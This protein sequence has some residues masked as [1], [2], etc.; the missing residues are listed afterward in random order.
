MNYSVKILPRAEI[1]LAEMYAYIALRSP[2]GAEQWLE[3]FEAVIERLEANPFLYVLAKE[4]C[5]FD[6]ELRQ[7]VFKTRH[8]RA[9]RAVYRVDE[10]RD[11]HSSDMRPRPS[12]LHC[13][14]TTELN[15]QLTASL[16]TTRYDI[17]F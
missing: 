2:D 1:D 9:Y 13:G 6:F 15:R 11:L 4:D 3:A 14:S 7:I 5:H 12:S 10:K 17:A 16:P 8:G